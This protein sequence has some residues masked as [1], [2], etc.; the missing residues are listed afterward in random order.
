MEFRKILFQRQ[1]NVLELRVI[2]F[3]RQVNVLEFRVK[4]FE[5]QVKVWDYLFHNFERKF[6]FGIALLSCLKSLR[7][8]LKFGILFRMIFLLLKFGLGLSDHS[9]SKLK[10][11]ILQDFSQCKLNF[12]IVFY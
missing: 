8:K 6:K 5:R 7:G 4:L 1:V 11:G 3:E 9:K 2:L 10:F 12:G